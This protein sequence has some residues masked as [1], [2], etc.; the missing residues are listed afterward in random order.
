V[1]AAQQKPQQSV[2]ES[3]AILR[4]LVSSRGFQALTAA[5][6]FNDVGSWALVSWQATFY[7]RV[8]SLTP[9]T[10]APLLAVVIPVGGLVGGVGAGAPGCGHPRGGPGGGRRSRCA[11]LW[12]SPWGAW[13]GASEQVRTP[14]GRAGARLGC[15]APVAGPG[16]SRTL[17]V[18]GAAAGSPAGPPHMRPNCRWPRLSLPSPHP[19][20]TYPFPYSH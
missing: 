11:W 4:T 20:P 7:Q 10:Y 16:G 1:A 2:G 3:L 12:S 15:R 8:F 5:A 17:P 18:L 14:G 19:T 6:A 9:D 13:W